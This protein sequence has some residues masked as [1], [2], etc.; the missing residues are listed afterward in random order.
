LSDFFL[1]PAPN[2]DGE[3]VYSYRM[4]NNGHPEEDVVSGTK[5]YTGYEHA[6]GL[7]V[8]SVGTEG[9]ETQNYLLTGAFGSYPALTDEAFS[10]LSTAVYQAR[11]TAFTD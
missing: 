4:M 7:T 2:E 3:Y 11:L 10:G 9:T 5:R 6:T 8:Q 1:T